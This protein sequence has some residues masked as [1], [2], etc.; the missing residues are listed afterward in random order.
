MPTETNPQAVDRYADLKAFVAEWHRPLAPGDGYTEAEIAEAEARLGFRLPEALRE[1]YALL[2]KREDITSGHNRLVYLQD[3][4]VEDDWLVV[5][6]E[7]QCV[8]LFAIKTTDFALAEPLVWILT[9]GE[10]SLQDKPFSVV[11]TALV[12][13]AYETLLVGINSGVGN[14][15]SKAD[16]D[17]LKS[18]A[19]P[20]SHP[21]L[22]Q[23][24]ILKLNELLL[25]FVGDNEVWIAARNRTELIQAIENYKNIEWSYTSLD[26]E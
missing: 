13:V 2:G 7:N 4:N 8:S 15:K 17:D 14:S 20:T 3:L 18:L 5:W 19:I 23:Y 16:I 26:D 1:L 11:Q 10:T 22:T 9:D 21:V 24:G 6:E 25:D 12:M